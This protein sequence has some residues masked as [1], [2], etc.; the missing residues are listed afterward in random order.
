MTTPVM[1]TQRRHA[2]IDASAG[3]AG[4][5]LLAAL[6]DAGAELGLVQQAVDAVGRY[7]MH[8]PFGLCQPGEHRCGVL[9]DPWRKVSSSKQVPDRAP[10]PVRWV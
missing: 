1:T 5:M 8:V 9:A 6:V 7:A 2:W 3:T 4:D 10:G